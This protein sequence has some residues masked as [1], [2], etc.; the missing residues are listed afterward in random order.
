MYLN[1]AKKAIAVYFRYSFLER[2]SRVE[3]EKSSLILENSKFIVKTAG[4]Y[5]ALIKIFLKHFRETMTESSLIGL[6]EDFYKSTLRTSGIIFTVA[7]LTGISFSALFNSHIGLWGWI[8]RG[9]LL[10]LGV[11]SLASN[12]DWPSLKN[13]SVIFRI[14]SK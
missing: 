3:Q 12:V 1:R 11:S 9:I 10:F 5:K 13:S 8:I 4:A 6:K 7:V 2:V 14:F